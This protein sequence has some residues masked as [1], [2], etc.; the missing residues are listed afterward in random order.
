MSRF[1]K[2]IMKC[3]IQYETT[4]QKQLHLYSSWFCAELL[5]YWKY[6]WLFYSSWLKIQTM[7]QLTNHFFRG[8]FLGGEFI[9]YF[10]CIYT[11]LVHIMKSTKK[12]AIKKA[13]IYLFLCFR[14]CNFCS[15][16]LF[17]PFRDRIIW[18]QLTSGAQTFVS[19]AL[20]AVHDAL[21]LSDSNRVHLLYLGSQTLIQVQDLILSEKMFPPPSL[22]CHFYNKLDFVQKPF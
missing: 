2:I 21:S 5:K 3:L 17:K 18:E 22:I 15:Y 20:E 16:T 14:K 7:P 8:V 4:E 11:F 6:P 9:F 12:K 1:L 13:I 10:F 19:E